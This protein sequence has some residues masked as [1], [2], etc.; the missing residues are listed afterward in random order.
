MWPQPFLG[1]LNVGMKQLESENSGLLFPSSKFRRFVLQP[2]RPARHWFQPCLRFSC[3]CAPAS[4]PQP[5]AG[6]KPVSATHCL[7]VAVPCVGHWPVF[8]DVLHTL[9]MCE[10]HP[11]QVTCR[12]SCPSF[13]MN[14][15]SQRLKLTNAWMSELLGNVEINRSWDLGN[16]VLTP[17]TSQYI[18]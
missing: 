2:V 12:C 6:W 17:C 14:V 4:W 8:V 16:H 10:V 11:F 3:V 15:C 1:G 9:P 13:V 18:W 7:A 5:F